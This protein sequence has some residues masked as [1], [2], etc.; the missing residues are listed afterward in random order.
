ML[1]MSWVA[2][3]RARTECHVIYRMEAVC[4]SHC[5]CYICC[6]DVVEA[7]A[8]V[9]NGM[10]M[11]LSNHVANDKISE[12]FRS[13]L[14]FLSHNM[15]CD[16][17]RHPR[18][19]CLTNLSFATWLLNIPVP[20]YW[21][22]VMWHQGCSSWWAKL[23][24]VELVTICMSTRIERSCVHAIGKV[25]KWTLQAFRKHQDILKISHMYNIHTSH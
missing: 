13:I 3:I 18:P 8:A 25:I 1:Y 4:D 2:W 20:L 16:W 21:H 15:F 11:L 7:H 5:M 22:A 14:V 19:N 24:Q 6:H 17:Q 10:G 23:V 12:K 9:L